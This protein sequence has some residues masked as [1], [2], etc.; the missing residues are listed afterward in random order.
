M[1]LATSL[2]AQDFPYATRRAPLLARNGIVASSSPIAAQAGLRMLL[3]GGNAVDAALATAITL[4]VVEPWVNGI[5]SDLFS[6]VW[7]G[8]KLHGLNGSGRAPATHTPALFA[9]L[10]LTEMPAAGWLP[11]TVPGAPRAWSDMHTRFGKLPFEE[12][13]E[14]AIDYAENGFALP[15]ETGAVWGATQVNYAKSRIGPEF[16]GWYSTFA[17]GERPARAGDVWSLPDHGKTLR[18]IAA[19]HSEDF[20][21]GDL[22]GSI[23]AFAAETSQQRPLQCCLPLM[24]SAP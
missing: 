1:T 3:K 4:T 8:S 9:R 24:K 17:P 20:Y 23:A 7:D 16:A 2:T 5:G 18:R 13:F 14:P 11:V 6:L 15:P 22:A 12:L 10:G 19:T 21:D